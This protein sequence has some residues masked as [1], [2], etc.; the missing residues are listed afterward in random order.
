[1]AEH[2]TTPDGISALLVADG[3]HRAEAIKAAVV[4]AAQLGAE[5]VA[6]KCPKM[7]RGHLRQSVIAEANPPEVRVDAPYAGVI[8]AGSLLQ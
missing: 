4:E 6:S 1:M 2:V 3:R 8:E 5:L 7:W